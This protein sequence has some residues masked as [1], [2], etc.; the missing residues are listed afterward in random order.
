[1]V[2]SKRTGINSLFGRDRAFT[3]V[4]RSIFPSHSCHTSPPT[5]DAM[6]TAEQRCVE[7]VR[8]KV[9]QGGSSRLSSSPAKWEPQDTV[10][11]SSLAQ[12]QLVKEGLR[13]FIR[14]VIFIGCCPF[15]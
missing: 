12:H 10:T 4:N 1:M 7:G 15:H 11:T 5:C 9:G 3:N 14:M 13:T 6:R 2:P 8:K